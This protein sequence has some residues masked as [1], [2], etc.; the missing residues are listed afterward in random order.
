MNA[1]VQITMP[2]EQY[3]KN[4]PTLIQMGLLSTQLESSP[5]ACAPITT[6]ATKKTTSRFYF[7]RFIRE[8]GLLSGHRLL[9]PH[10]QEIILK[11]ENGHATVFC[12]NYQH[13][14]IKG[15]QPT[16]LGAHIKEQ[17]GATP[18]SD[19]GRRKHA[20]CDGPREFWIRHNNGDYYYLADSIWDTLRF[21]PVSNSFIARS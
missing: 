2:L 1:T 15:D 3:E 14:S 5:L 19:G 4:R 8:L 17:F 12:K 20:H 7:Q 21:D 9:G 16:G 13:S 18:L 6:E 10:N 11:V